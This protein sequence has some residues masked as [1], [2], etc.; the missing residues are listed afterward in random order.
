MIASS[1]CGP[2]LPEFPHM[3]DIFW[4]RG[5]LRAAQGRL[6]EALDDLHEYGRRCGR[7]EMRTPAIPWRAD[8][9]LLH[10]RLGDRDAAERLASEYDE[11]ARAWDTPRVIGISA[12]TRGLIDGGDPGLALLHEAVEAH[13]TSP[14]RLEHARSLLELGAA[15]RRAGRRTDALEPLRQAAELAHRCGATVL[16]ARAGEELGVA[17]AVGRRYAFSGADALTPS[18]RRV[19]GM[20]AEGRTNREIAQ[21][22]F[23]TAK[24]VENHL[25]RVY[26]KLAIGSRAELAGALGLAATSPH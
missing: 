13:A 21:T 10:S 25:G 15:L 4:A 18:E 8:A 19:A 2:Q 5:R 17:G 22:L 6:H 9:A 1:G 23:V 11:L 26:T 14:A 16:A 3:N 12:R 7:A 24:T 20:A